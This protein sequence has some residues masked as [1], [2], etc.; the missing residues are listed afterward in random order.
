MKITK[1]NSRYIANNIIENSKVKAKN[2]IERLKNDSI[3]FTSLNK[4][5]KKQQPK[6]TYAA[7]GAL[8]LSLATNTQTDKITSN[9]Q[10]KYSIST[11]T[12]TT[13]ADDKTNTPAPNQIPDSSTFEIG[14]S[15][16]EIEE[17]L[18]PETDKKINT[19][20]NYTKKEEETLKHIQ[21]LKHRADRDYKEFIDN[22]WKHFPKVYFAT[23]DLSV[24]KKIGD[25]GNFYYI[26]SEGYAEWYDNYNNIIKISSGE[27]IWN[28]AKT[29]NDAVR[30][31]RETIYEARKN[32]ADDIENRAGAN[33]TGG[34][35]INTGEYIAIKELLDG[36]SSINDKTKYISDV[37]KE[38]LE[39][40]RE[41]TKKEIQTENCL[42]PAF[43]PE[44]MQIKNAT[45]IEKS[46]KKMQTS[47]KAISE[48]M[49][50]YKTTQNKETLSEIIDNCH[51]FS[52]TYFDILRMTNR[53]PSPENDT[54]EI[55]SYIADDAIL[56]AEFR[57]LTENNDIQIEA[58]YIFYSN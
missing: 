57:L 49:K 10:N 16:E 22:I 52:N 28:S 15:E 56:N 14:L 53:F 26:P 3:S 54:R 32:F 55:H 23:K 4:N 2:N 9:T 42:I 58:P 41:K 19:S 12:E 20:R 44:D 43:N 7:L 29:A 30:L 1:I 37:Y 38:E 50:A 51:N 6:W 40:A 17:Y 35:D 46:Y 21:H 11:Q 27:K 48:L 24:H 5:N 18:N 8:I 47:K 45:S 25:S 39:S 31:I 33:A 36:L 34:G 13:K